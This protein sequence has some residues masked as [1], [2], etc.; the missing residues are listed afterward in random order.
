M[1]NGVRVRSVCAF[2]KRKVWQ[3]VPL[4]PSAFSSLVVPPLRELLVS[5]PSP[6]ISPSFSLS[7]SGLQERSLPFGAFQ[8]ASLNKLVVPVPQIQD[9]ILEILKIIPQDRVQQRT[10][11]QT[12]D[13]PIPHTGSTLP[14]TLWGK[15]PVRSCSEYHQKTAEHNFLYRQ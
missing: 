2:N 4:R 13:I 12:V 11:V 6:S 5:S 7:L 14:S 15:V 9:R 3:Q 10:E 1:F 8:S